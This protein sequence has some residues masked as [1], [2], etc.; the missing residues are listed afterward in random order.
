[1]TETTEQQVSKPVLGSILPEKAKPTVT[2]EEGLIEPNHTVKFAPSS[3]INH[4][5]EQAPKKTQKKDQ[6]QKD[7][8]SIP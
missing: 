5:S 6:E 2:L 4:R 8:D 3:P 1:M 7:T